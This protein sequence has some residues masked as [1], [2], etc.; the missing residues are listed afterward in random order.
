M[1]GVHQI[2]CWGTLT[3]GVTVF[4]PAMA[5]RSGASVSAIMAAYALGLVVN[6]FVAPAATRWVMRGNA[7]L[8]GL[9]GL[10]LGVAAC[11][12]LAFGGHLAWVAVGFALAGAAM[13][14]AQYDFA[15]LC[16]RLYHPHDARRVVTGV[17][18]FG[19]VASSIMWPIAVALQA[20]FGLTVGWLGLGGIMASVG[21]VSLWWVT[22]SAILPKTSKTAPQ[23]SQ[24]LAETEAGDSHHAETPAIPAAQFAPNTNCAAGMAGFS[25]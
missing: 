9:A 19:A 23:V 18:L 12:V 20:R 21:G 11:V 14:M 22:R 16:V 25:A 6:G 15:W 1:L 4:A 8:G 24:D 10:A 13:A 7:W 3:Y 5:A 2:V 17:T